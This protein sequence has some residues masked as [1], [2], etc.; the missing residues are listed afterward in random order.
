MN[1]L[2]HAIYND[3]RV[4]EQVIQELMAV[5]IAENAILSVTSAMANSA[6]GQAHMGSFADSGAHTHDA[7][8]DH[9]GGFADSKAHMHD[10]ER[11]HVGSFAD[12]GTH[13]HG[14]ARDRVG[15]FADSASSGPNTTL[16]E[17][18]VRAGLSPAD[19]QAAIARLAMAATLVLVRAEGEAADRAAAI[20]R[21]AG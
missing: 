4:A 15:G 2:V 17:N 10:A 16:A 21:S 14:A 11:D 7:E 12:S 6:A 13:T 19:A 18:L 3:A 9:V 1:T 8:R 20:L 5:G